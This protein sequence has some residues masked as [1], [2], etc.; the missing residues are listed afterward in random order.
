MRWV[1]L[2][3]V[4]EPPRQ[5]ETAL[6][7]CGAEATFS[8]RM[9]SPQSYLPTPVLDLLLF[10]TPPRFLLSQITRIPLLD[11]GKSMKFVMRSGLGSMQAGLPPSRTCSLWHQYGTPSYSQL[12]HPDQHALCKC[13]VCPRRIQP[14]AWDTETPRKDTVLQMRQYHLEFEQVFLSGFSFL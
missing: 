1:Q 3:G 14:A 12:P 4:H 11:C 6:P 7:L 10:L 2:C 5:E 13:P 9:W 8:R